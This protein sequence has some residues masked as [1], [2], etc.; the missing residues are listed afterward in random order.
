[1]TCFAARF[2]RIHRAY[3]SRLILWE[4]E[5]TKFYIP[6]DFDKILRIQYGDYTIL[7]PENRRNRPH[8][9]NAFRVV[10]QGG[11]ADMALC[12]LNDKNPSG[13]AQEQKFAQIEA[14]A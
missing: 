1:M 14:K 9:F 2:L 7:P 6:E 13:A 5:D 3:F 11:D 12:A 4:F 8:R 10:Y